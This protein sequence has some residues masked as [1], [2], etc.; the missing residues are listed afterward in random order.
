M[1]RLLLLLIVPVSLALAWFQAPPVWV[2]A[3][4][5]VATAVLADRVREATEHLAERVGGALGSLLNVSF[6]SI[7]ELLLALFVL[8]GGQAAV[9]QAQVTGSIIG[10]GLLGL[11]M[12]MLAGGI[13]RE[14]QLFNRDAIGLLSTMLTVVL[15]ALLLPA[16]FDAT[17]RAAVARPIVAIADEHLSLGVAVVLIALY[18]INLVYTLVTH[19]RVFTAAKDGEETGEGGTTQGWSVAR[20]LTVLVVV[21]AVV[22]LEAELVSRSLEQ[23]AELLHLS[24]MFLGVVVLALVGTAAD[25]FAAIVFARDDRMTMVFN[26]C[27]GSA[28][29]MAMVV[30]PILVLVSWLIGT[31][32]NLVFGNPLDLL[33]IGGTAFVVRAVT[34]DGETT[35]YEG[36][37]LIGLYALLAMAFFFAAG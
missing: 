7:A 13:G 29:Q 8:T 33:A 30:A 11:G 27:I 21:T 26:I 22:A 37:L 9:V 19:R 14:K 1:L 32:M 16:V 34:A 36:V 24:S 4:G 35:W 20:S 25:L 15:I 12:A 6:G 18:L 23:T 28:I 17:Q 5:A 3:A 2:F 31:P 10:T